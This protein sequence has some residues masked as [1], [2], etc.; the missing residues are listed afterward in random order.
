MDYENLKMK[1]KIGANNI[2]LTFKIVSTHR[3]KLRY[4]DVFHLSA[5]TVIRFSR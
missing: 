1:K 5:G 4:L 2:A 3:A